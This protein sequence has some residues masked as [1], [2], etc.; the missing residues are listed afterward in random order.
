MGAELAD[1]RA[2]AQ[3][4]LVDLV[5]EHDRPFGAHAEGDEDGQ[6]VRR[7]VGPGGRFDLGEDVGGEGLLDLQAVGRARR[8]PAAL[9]RHLDAELGE[10]AVEKGELLHRAVPHR[11]LAAGDGSHRQEGGHFVEVI[12]KSEFG[13]RQPIDPLHHD[14]RAADAFDAGPHQGEEGAELLHMGFAGSVGQLRAPRSRGCA[15]DEVL[16]RGHRGVVEPVV[17]DPKAGGGG[18]VK[19]VGL[20]ADLGPEGLE[21]R[22]VGVDFPG[23]QGAARCILLDGRRAEPVEQGRDQHE[24]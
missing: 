13:T 7:D 8:R 18:D 24:G 10:G 23:A 16:G 6:E 9:V 5:P 21:D 19:G 22:D 20:A 17:R 12:G 15:E 14:A 4:P 2:P 11:D 1:L 3:G